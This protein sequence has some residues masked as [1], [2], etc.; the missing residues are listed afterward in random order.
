MFGPVKN[1]PIVSSR[2]RENGVYIVF[3][4]PAEFL[5]TDPAGNK[6]EVE[7]LGDR[8]LIDPADENTAVDSRKIYHFQLPLAGAAPR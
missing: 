1:D 7:V 8:L 5:V 3:V 2:S 6:A 4:H